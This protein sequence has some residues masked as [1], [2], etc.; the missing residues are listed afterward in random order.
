MQKGVSSNVWRRDGTVVLTV[1][2]A[3]DTWRTVSVGVFAPAWTWSVRPNE[4]I[5][6]RLCDC[7]DLVA[8]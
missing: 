5:C 3:R 7:T 2:G 1:R 8:N 6:V 4:T